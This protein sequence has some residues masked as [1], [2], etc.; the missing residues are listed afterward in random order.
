MKL[1]FGPLKYYRGPSIFYVF[2]FGHPVILHD[3]HSPYGHRFRTSDVN[4]R[5]CLNTERHF[6]GGNPLMR[7]HVCASSTILKGSEREIIEFR[8]KSDRVHNIYFRTTLTLERHDSFCSHPNYRS[9]S[10]VVLAL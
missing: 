1:L 4:T 2:S 10:R 5:S 7:I 9:N 8:W 3:P 6:D